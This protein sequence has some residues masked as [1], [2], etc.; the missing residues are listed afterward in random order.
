MAAELA[1][2]ASL[3]GMAKTRESTARAPKRLGA[4]TLRWM[5]R[6]YPPLAFAGVRWRAV[7][8]SCESARVDVVKGLRNRNINGTVFGGALTAAVDPVMALLLWQA[9]ARRGRHV[10]AWTVNLDVAFLRA[11]RTDVRFDFAIAPG[12]LDAILSELDVCGR[13]HRVHQVQG[14][15]RDGAVCVRVE[16]AT[17]VRDPARLAALAEA[18][19]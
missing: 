13:S 3:R 16:I 11:A 10:E 5:M 2:W 14:V 18:S 9:I 8:P 6:C 19:D 7:S 4:G 17:L 15:D 1:N 12:E